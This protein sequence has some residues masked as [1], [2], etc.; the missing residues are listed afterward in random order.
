MEKEQNLKDFLR[1]FHRAQDN[2]IF[3]LEEYWNKV[4]PDKSLELTD[5]EKQE[6]YTNNK[7]MVPL[8]KNDDSL[9]KYEEEVAKK[10]AQGLKDWEIF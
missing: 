2:A 3:F 5:E 8:F 4:H 1:D 9:R 10:R 6:I 7:I